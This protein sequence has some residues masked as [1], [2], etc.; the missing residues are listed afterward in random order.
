M[1]SLAGQMDVLIKMMEGLTIKDSTAN[2]PASDSGKGNGNNCSTVDPPLT[3]WE[4]EDDVLKIMEDLLKDDDDGDDNSMVDTCSA[5][6]NGGQKDQQAFSTC[7]QTDPLL[8]GICL[9]QA[10]VRGFLTRNLKP[11]ATVKN[12]SSVTEDQ[13]DDLIKMMKG[14]TVKDSIVDASDKDGNLHSTVDSPMA[15]DWEVDDCLDSLVKDMEALLNDEDVEIQALWTGLHNGDHCSS[16]KKRPSSETKEDVLD[17]VTDRPAKK[18]RFF[19][20]N[21]EESPT[22]TRSAS[23]STAVMMDTEPTDEKLPFGSR[24]P[25]FWDP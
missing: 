8:K 13:M 25:L 4:E 15:G 21:N 16:K 19:N 17:A 6:D 7:A 5:S 1:A 9:L 10:H 23:P 18:A 24:Q 20:R 2:V 14:L 12:A 3:D 22:I 11:R